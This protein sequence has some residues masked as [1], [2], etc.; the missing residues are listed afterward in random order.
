MYKQFGEL[1]IDTYFEI[2]ECCC[3]ISDYFPLYPTLSQHPRHT[4]PKLMV[5]LYH[6]LHSRIII[7]SRSFI[8]KFVTQY[9]G[10]IFEEISHW[11][12]FLNWGSF[13]GINETKLSSFQGFWFLLC[14]KLS[15]ISMRMDS[16]EL[17]T[18]FNN[19]SSISQ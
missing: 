12:I 5:C 4:A 1:I 17:S 9:W 2:R 8:W 7:P 18:K 14:V 15:S 3:L 10:I 13:H 19:F 6:F 11:P 16:W